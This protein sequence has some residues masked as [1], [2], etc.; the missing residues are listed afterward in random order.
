MTKLYEAINYDKYIGKLDKLTFD[1]IIGADPTPDKKY[2]RWLVDQFLKITDNRERFLKQLHYRTEDL[3]TYDLYK[4]SN[5]LPDEYKDIF[6]FK[7]FNDLYLYLQNNSEQLDKA[8]IEKKAD[9]NIK[10][11]YKDERLILVQS[12]SYEA[13]V[14][15]GTGTSWCTSTAS[16]DG[17]YNTYSSEGELYIQRWYKEDGSWYTKEDNGYKGF[18]LYIPGNKAKYHPVVECNYLSNAK[19]PVEAFMEHLPEEIAK[20]LKDKNELALHKHRYILKY[21]VSVVS[22]RRNDDF[23]HVDI[24]GEYK[25]SDKNGVGIEDDKKSFAYEIGVMKPKDASALLG[26]E[27]QE[28]GLSI[29][30]P[31]LTDKQALNEAFKTWN[32]VDEKNLKIY[33]QVDI[34][35]DFRRLTEDFAKTIS[36]GLYHYILARKEDNLYGHLVE[37]TI[38]I[39][40]TE[41][42]QI[43]YTIKELDSQWMMYI[44]D[45]VKETQQENLNRIMSH[46]P[47]LQS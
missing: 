13:S 1:R 17:H 5:V 42:Y 40:L 7:T 19:A 3:T 24:L 6:K 30:C 20:F 45:D 35:E 2:S 44:A 21:L 28:Y 46:L 43:D 47:N 23:L 14:K 36:G 26:Y 29:S 27:V 16:S 31:K 22:G 11:L 34:D 9:K 38:F 4:K 18:Q 39:F 15:Y 41:R 33:G 10:V 32:W 12:L 8:V 37:N 25:L